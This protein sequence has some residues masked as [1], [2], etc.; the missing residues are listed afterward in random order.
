MADRR[1]QQWVLRFA[2]EYAD[3]ADLTA[4]VGDINDVIVAELPIFTDS[5]L[6]RD[7]A[8]SSEAQV[9]GFIT[10]TLGDV[11]QV[12][13]PDA[14]HD[15]ARSLARRGLE[16]RWLMR[17]YRVGLQA[18]LRALTEFVAES[19]DEP[20]PDMLREVFERATTWMVVSMERLTDTYTLERERGLREAFAQR[21]ETVADILGGGT[22]DLDMASAR[23]GYRLR[24]KHIGYVLWLEDAAVESAVLE[25]AA[26]QAAAD[27]PVLT[28]PSG[29]RGLW[30]W[31]ATDT[32]A[33][34][35][36]RVRIAVGAAAAGL[37]GFRRTHREAVAAREFADTLGRYTAV[38]YRDIEIAHLLGAD[39]EG[40]RALVAR[41]LHGIAGRDPNSARLRET[42]RAYLATQRSL[43]GAARMLGVHKNTVRYRIQRT[44]ELVDIENRRLPVELA[45]ECVARYGDVILP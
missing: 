6:R 11:D 14:A 27:A 1:I 40:L 7:L 24:G 34:V 39:R 15:L 38:A 31:A 9:R 17:I 10:A 28:V 4:L 32:L 26:G 8:E 23:L 18:A 41:E 2:G 43:E 36:S 20:E 3:P 33:P 13:V 12:D 35:D 44:A 16:L 45:L 29:A 5:D 42:L 30:A 22:V 19:G 21:A 25:R 37:D